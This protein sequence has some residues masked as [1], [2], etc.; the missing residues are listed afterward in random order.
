MDRLISIIIVNYN[1]K[2]LLHQC[3]SSVISDTIAF[4]YEIIVVD[5]AS[6]DGSDQMVQNEFPGVR[7]IKKNMNVGYA[8][9]INE[10][11]INSKGQILIVT[12]S[13]IVFPAGAINALV[14]TLEAYDHIGVIGP[15]LLY[16]D[17]KWQRN[18]GLIPGLWSV[19]QDL[20][21][22]NAIR[23]A[24]DWFAYTCI[25][26][27]GC[28]LK[29]VGYIDGAVMA[30]K[31]TVLQKVGSFD[32]RFFF[33]FEDAD[34][35]FRVWQAGWSVFLASHIYAIHYRGASSTSRDPVYYARLLADSDLLF[36]RKHYTS[37]MVRIYIFLRLIYCAQRIVLYMC[38]LSLS[39]LINCKLYA[40]ASVRFRVF[41]ALFD[42]YK[43]MLLH[44]C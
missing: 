36:V 17:K 24:L 31:R 3:L 9:A 32:E 1:T 18:Y 11:L 14:K 5:N 8:R 23:R 41:L 6:T 19:V 20:T 43:Q 44:G 15:Q 2:Q 39:K 38:L 7:L 22:L 16:P 13:D 26:R 37:H 30:I 40:V 12:N 29:P 25:K 21:F 33:Y 28:C 42:V 34:F 4:N 35:C 27:R 10:G